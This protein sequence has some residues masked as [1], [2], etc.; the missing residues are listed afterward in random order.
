MTHD[1]IELPL[2]DLDDPHATDAL[3]HGLFDTGFFL[4]ADHVI[5]RQLLD[6]VRSVTL[7]FMAKPVA[8]KERFV[9][10]LRGW[11]AYAAENVATAYGAEDAQTGPDLCEKFSMGPFITDDMR[12]A[13]PDYYE[14][15]ACQ[16]FLPDNLFPEAEME[17]TWVD[18]YDRMQELCFRLLDAI[19]VVMKLPQGVWDHYTRDAPSVLRF[20]A[21][22]D[23]T[24]SHRMGAH[25]D[26]TLLTVLHQSVPTNGFAALQVQLPGSD[27]WRS[28]VP[29]DDVF[30]VN[31]GEALT[32]LSGGRIVATKHRVISPSRDQAEGSARTS[33]A[34]FFLPR[35]NA[36]LTPTLPKANDGM[37]TS[38]DTPGLAEPDGSV[39]FHKVSRGQV[40]QMFGKDTKS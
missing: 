27:E 7:E 18:Y 19:R 17:R 37:R 21:Y 32:F 2:V 35:W 13:E 8:D 23:N 12:R 22:P 30:V 4:L 39:I 38:L 3:R 26:D 11:T 25:F 36:A 15:P 5:P 9:G 20:L 28:V 31:V 33:L 24:G 40:D 10:P 29:S 16:E 14:D 34:H 1:A 6:E